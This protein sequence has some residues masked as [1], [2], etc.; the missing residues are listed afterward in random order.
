MSEGLFERAVERTAARPKS[1]RA[2]DPQ[3]DAARAAV[4]K[5]ASE[6][7]VR[8]RPLDGGLSAALDRLAA[9]EGEAS[10]AQATIADVR[11]RAA[12]GEIPPETA[13][14]LS[15]AVRSEAEKELVARYKAAEEAVSEARIRA[16]RSFLPQVERDGGKTREAK[17][18]LRLAL[19]AGGKDVLAA[20]LG[21]ARQAVRT[22]DRVG[23]ALLAGEW[24]RNAWSA[25][26]GDPKA[27]EEV[28]SGFLTEAVN[29]PEFAEASTVQ[30]LRALHSKAVHEAVVGTRE[31][32]GY[33]VGDLAGSE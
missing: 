14:R 28:R 20:F 22:K 30:T 2:S 29:A 15:A 7:R 12:A 11:R 1:G 16:L 19:D 31:A 17:D 6:A 23:L 26:G 4:R 24:G 13:A 25:R 33:A 8:V 10:R 27:F 9:L 18:D 32:V 5:L 21:A 3:L